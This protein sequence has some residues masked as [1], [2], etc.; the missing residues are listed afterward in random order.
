MSLLTLTLGF[1][2]RKE[3]NNLK[4]RIENRKKIRKKLSPLLITLTVLEI[5]MRKT[6]KLSRRPN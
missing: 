3:E 6:N 1:K 4:K 5:K 2:N